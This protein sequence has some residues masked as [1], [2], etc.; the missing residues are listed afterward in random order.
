MVF[1]FRNSSRPEAV[2]PQHRLCRGAA[3]KERT[4]TLHKVESFAL[5]AFLPSVLPPPLPAPCALHP[6]LKTN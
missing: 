5:A 3:E 1:W 6:G 4:R 2:A